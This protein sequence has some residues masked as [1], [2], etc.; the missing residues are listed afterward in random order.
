MNEDSDFFGLPVN[1]DEY[2]KFM[3]INEWPGKL[4][5]ENILPLREELKDYQD[6][7]LIKDGLKADIAI[8]FFSLDEFQI[9]LTVNDECY[10][11]I[12]I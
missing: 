6:I 11:P 4:T 7:D 3:E 9:K 5:A 2:I 8:S 12:N 10:M 1:Y